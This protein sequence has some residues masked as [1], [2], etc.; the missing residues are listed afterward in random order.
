MSISTV[1]ESPA[2][3]NKLR[4]QK[5]P[6]EALGSEFCKP[7]NWGSFPVVKPNRRTRSRRDLATDAGDM[8]VIALVTTPLVLL[9]V[10]L[11][12]GFVGKL[13]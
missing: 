5:P 8:V 2:R 7:E 13:I 6:R 3:T 4:S 11:L 10:V 12:A 1:K 9:V